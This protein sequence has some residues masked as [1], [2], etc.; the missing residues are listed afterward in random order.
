M[1]NVGLSG[2]L[3]QNTLIRTL[4]FTIIEMIQ[5]RISVGAPYRYNT[6]SKFSIWCDIF[7]LCAVDSLISITCVDSIG[8]LVDSIF[9]DNEWLT[10]AELRVEKFNALYECYF[11]KVS[12]DCIIISSS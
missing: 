12:S 2:R 4:I 6:P 1:C 9:S 8:M 3:I 11:A 7:V 5:K 10:I